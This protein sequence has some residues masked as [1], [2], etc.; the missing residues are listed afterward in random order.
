MD[1]YSSRAVSITHTQLPCCTNLVSCLVGK[2]QLTLYWFERHS[3]LL[4]HHFHIHSFIGLHPDH[5][6]ITT[7][8]A[9]KDITRYVTELDTDLGFA[10]I[11]S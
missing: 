9:G 3:W 4:G 5:K 11:Q 7:G 10:L 2:I 1:S 6:L 8:F